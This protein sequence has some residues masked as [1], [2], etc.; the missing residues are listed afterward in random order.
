MVVR[1]EGGMA[2]PLG[3]WDGV[4]VGVKGRVERGM[5]MILLS[6]S[7]EAEVFGEVD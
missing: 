3:S 4:V 6:A 5:R 2:E 7:G 1:L